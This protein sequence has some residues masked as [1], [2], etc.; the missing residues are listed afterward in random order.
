[1]KKMI[2][3]FSII[4]ILMTMII[5][6]GCD[7][8]ANEKVTNEIN[9]NDL[10]FRIE[11]EDLEFAMDTGCGTNSVFHYTW[12]NNDNELETVDLRIDD[13]FEYVELK[14]GTITYNTGAEQ[15]S[16]DAS[17]ILF[18]QTKGVK[19]IDISN[20][21]PTHYANVYFNMIVDDKLI[22]YKVYQNIDVYETEYCYVI[23]FE[24]DWTTYLSKTY[25]ISTEALK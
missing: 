19:K 17:K 20:V 2:K 8:V 13:K 12:Y 23:P 3:I 7:N 10:E 16:I 21:I 1:M 6:T 18:W 11:K 4:F 22:L 14:E 24:D 5:L 15:G 25:K 9:F